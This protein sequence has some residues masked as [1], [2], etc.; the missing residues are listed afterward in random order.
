MHFFYRLVKR[1]FNLSQKKYLVFLISLIMIFVF[2]YFY[3]INIVNPIILTNSEIRVRSMTVQAINGAVADVVAE[4]VLY[5]DLVNIVTNEQGKIIMLNANSIL[6]NKLSKEL[7]KQAQNKLKTMGDG[8]MFIPLGNFTGIPLFVGLGPNIKV[9]IIPVGSIKC[10]FESK[11][12]DGGINQTHHRIYVNIEASVNMILP[13][14]NISVKSVSQVL[15][16]ECI[17]VG[18]V[19]STYLYSNSLQDMLDLIPD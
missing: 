10:D 7:A 14:K 13:V 12:E 19:P 6:I 15:I 5:S 2:V 4:S 18:E 17:I 11:F 1:I 9:H 16:S 8:G 3:F